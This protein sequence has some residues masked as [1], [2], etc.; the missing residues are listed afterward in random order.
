MTIADQELSKYQRM[1]AHPSYRH[2]SPGERAVNDFLKGCAWKPGDTLTDVGAGTGRAGRKLAAQG[3]RVTLLD[4]CP[5]ANETDLPCRQ[6]ILWDLP[7]SIPRFDWIYCVDVLEHIPPEYVGSTLDALAAIT[8]KGG[9]LQIALF[10]DGFGK[11]IGERLHLTV[12]PL[13]WWKPHISARWSDVTVLPSNGSYAK[14]V[15]GAPK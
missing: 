6:V 2:G 13:D 4:C 5:E 12:K 7:A 11:L 15:M 3:L 1:W 9:Y 8:I 10:N 14:F